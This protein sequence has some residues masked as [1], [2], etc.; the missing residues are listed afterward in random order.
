MSGR[1]VGVNLQQVFGRRD[2][3]TDVLT[4]AL[5]GRRDAD[6]LS[7][8]AA[9]ALKAL[10]GRAPYTAVFQSVTALAAP[11][12]P[13]RDVAWAMAGNLAALSAGRPVYV[14][15]W[16]AAPTD[17]P[18]Q[19]LAARRALFRNRGYVVLSARALAGPG[20]PARFSL[21]WGEK[22]ARYF[23]NHPEAGGLDG[24]KPTHYQHPYQLVGCRF[25]FRLRAAGGDVKVEQ[26]GGTPTLRAHNVAL[27]KMRL[28]ETYAC[29]YDYAHACHDC[30]V[31]QARCPA[32]THEQDWVTVQC[33][34]C[35]GRGPADPFFDAKTCLSCLSRTEP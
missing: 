30:P 3:L 32:A 22:A 6:A 25:V 31:G 7:D 17:V 16:P 2:R 35:A 19:I 5:N 1:R 21:R 34:T 9:A 24:S 11:A 33:G 14:G 27:A 12:L 20:C 28:R 10:N 8:A 23:A 4:T 13:V 15:T 29:P 18:V 26:V